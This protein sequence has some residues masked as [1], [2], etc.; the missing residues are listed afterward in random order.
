MEKVTGSSPVGSTIRN[1]EYKTDLDKLRH[2]CSH[3]MAQAVQ[4]LWP[5]TQVT[6]GPAI[7]NGF[8]YD[9]DRRDPFTDEDLRQIEKRMQ[10]IIQ[11]KPA[12]ERYIL[13]REEAIRLFDK[14]GEKSEEIRSPTRISGK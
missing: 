4:E 6:I 14:K 2:S 11:R 5:G 12:F 3:I 7:A 13:P 1:M 10:E 8:Y 9:F